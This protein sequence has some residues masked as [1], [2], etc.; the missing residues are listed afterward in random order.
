[1]PTSFRN[2][3]DLFTELL[4][5][6]SMIPEGI[7]RYGLHSMKS[8]TNEILKKFTH[9]PWPLMKRGFLENMAKM[10]REPLWKAYLTFPNLSQL[11][12]DN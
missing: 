5:Y 7:L 11:F 4:R 9:R 12:F 6:A 1:M 2:R 3:F 8:P 10:C